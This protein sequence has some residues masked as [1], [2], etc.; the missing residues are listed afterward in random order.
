MFET[1]ADPMRRRIVEE[2]RGGGR[3]VGSLVDVVD[4]RQ[5][6]V[7]R[8]LRILRE[9]GFVAVDP[10]GQ[11]RI[12]SLRPEPF[13]AL[14]GWLAAYRDLWEGRLDRL[15]VQLGRRRQATGGGESE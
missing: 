8:H 6:G 1:L 14:D 5:S 2:L 10:R 3:S 11:E 13:Q 9:A 12:Y 15:E 7:S 4:I